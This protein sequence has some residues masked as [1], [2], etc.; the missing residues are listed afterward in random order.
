MNDNKCDSCG[1]KDV[2]L[3]KTG[4]LFSLC[5]DCLEEKRYLK[6]D[7][8]GEYWSK[9][10][11]NFYETKDGRTVC[12]GCVEPSDLPN[13][14]TA[15]VFRAIK[16]GD[17]KVSYEAP[18]CFE[19]HTKPNGDEFYVICGDDVSFGCDYGST[20]VSVCGY[21][22]TWNPVESEWEGLDEDLDPEGHIAEALNDN[23]D[24]VCVSDCPDTE[25]LTSFYELAT[26]DCI[27]AY[28]YED[29][30]IPVDAEDVCDPEDVAE[31]IVTFKGKKYYLLEEPE[32]EEN[33][34][35]ETVFRATAIAEGARPDE[36]GVYDCV[37]VFMTAEKVDEEGEEYEC[38]EPYGVEDSDRTYDG[39][40]QGFN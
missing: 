34:D 5:K 12:S 39:V 17:F 21:T 31:E 37:D 4:D 9:E 27:E 11:Y 28:Y 22:F 36:N 13:E 8:C 7:C 3:I 40:N 10:V 23:D 20:T 32:E 14:D 26:G 35:G 33:I 19:R 24:I 25:E 16:N 30:D 2:E 15:K 6:C 29:L 1:K 18:N 38:G